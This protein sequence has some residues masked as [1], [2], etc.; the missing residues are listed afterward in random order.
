MISRQ[1]LRHIHGEGLPLHI[2]ELD[3]IESIALKWLFTRNDKV[4]FKGG[5]CLKKVH[6]LNRYSEDLD[7]A[8]ANKSVGAEDARDAVEIMAAGMERTGIPAY[9]KEWKERKDV[10]LC[11]LAYQGPLYNGQ[12]KTR[13]KIEIEISRFPPIQELEWNTVT[14][15]YADTGT[16]SIQSLSLS[17]ILAEKFRTLRT[18]NKPRDLYDIFFILKK[19]ARTNLDVINAKLSEVGA[20]PVDSYADAIEC[21]TITDEQWNRDLRLLILRV[22]DLQSI[23]SEI[24]RLLEI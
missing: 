12:E 18:R 15:N 22:P 6:G 14:S 16:H 7:F 19:G 2:L 11:K 24:M 20:E 1:Q 10:F 9:V 13:G 8:I 21:Y 17:E 4:A 5:T 23:R 3:Y